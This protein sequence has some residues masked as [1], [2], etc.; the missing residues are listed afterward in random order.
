MNTTLTAKQE[1]AKEK[2]QQLK[3]MSKAVKP[4]LEMGEFETVNEALIASY[5]SND[6]E[7]EEFKTFADWK[8]EGKKIV[9]G[10]T[11]FLIWGKKR[12]SKQEEEA[13][14]ETTEETKENYSYFPVCYLFANTQVN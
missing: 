1:A 2:R 7:I 8:K 13:P 3:S 4:L 10:S 9:K 11:A 6:P 5:K 14:E 12:K